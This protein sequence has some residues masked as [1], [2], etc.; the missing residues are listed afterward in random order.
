MKNVSAHCRC[1]NCHHAWEDR[2]IHVSKSSDPRIKRPTM[3]GWVW[4]TEECPAT[5]C[6]SIYWMRVVELQ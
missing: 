1:L 6:N 2:L 5:H 4:V 3:T